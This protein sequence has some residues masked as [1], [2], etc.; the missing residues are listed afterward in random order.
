MQER[1]ARNI[2]EHYLQESMVS[3]KL[4]NVDQ[5]VYSSELVLAT[6]IFLEWFQNLQRTDITFF[7][8]RQRMGRWLMGD[9]TTA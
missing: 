8:V 9:V 1:Y 5:Q 2:L 3:V 4:Q 7:P 6:Y